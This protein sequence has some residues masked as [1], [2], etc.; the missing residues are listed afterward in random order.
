MSKPTTT[1]QSSALRGSV[2]T[3]FAYGRSYS[4]PNSTCRFK[5][6]HQLEEGIAGRENKERTT[7]PSLKPKPAAYCG[8][9]S[10][11]SI[12]RSPAVEL[13]ETR[14][15]AEAMPVQPT[16]ASLPSPSVGFKCT[17]SVCGRCNSNQNSS[18]RSPSQ[19]YENKINNM[20]LQSASREVDHILILGD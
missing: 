9:I 11:V 1:S 4:K 20:N 3:V 16:Y 13:N 2:L 15:D 19:S 8:S 7:S 6:H 5:L 10:S 14:E 17:P 12:P 18:N